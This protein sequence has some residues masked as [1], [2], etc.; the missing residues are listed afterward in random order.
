V[1]IQPAVDAPDSEGADDDIAVEHDHRQLGVQRDA[2]R[3]RYGKNEVEPLG[4]ARP[5]IQR[6]SPGRG[7]GD[8]IR[9]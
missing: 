2:E 8:G 6:S 5:P 4:L 7:F 1:L 9:A 3:H